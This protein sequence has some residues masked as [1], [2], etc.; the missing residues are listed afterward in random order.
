MINFTFNNDLFCCIFSRINRYGKTKAD[1][2]AALRAIEIGAQVLLMTKNKVDGIYSDDPRKNPKAKKFDK[3]THFQA[4]N[5]RLEVMDATAF[6][7]CMENRIPIVVFN[8]FK[9]D[10][11]VRVLEGQPVGTLVTA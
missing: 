5:L 7:L 4:I 2:A 10:E 11:I 1:T 3:L 6:S 8:F 9:K